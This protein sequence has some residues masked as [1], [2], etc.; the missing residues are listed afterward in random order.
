[1][2]DSDGSSSDD[3]ND[4]PKDGVSVGEV[5]ARSNVVFAGYWEQPDQTNAAIV[6][7][8]ES[9]TDFVAE[10]TPTS[11]VGQLALDTIT[12]RSARSRPPSCSARALRLKRDCRLSL[13][14][15]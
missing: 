10:S 13:S 2:S 1:M 5:C 3:G 9:A 7:A 8:A 14:P 11:T 6:D 15:P 12:L 4:V